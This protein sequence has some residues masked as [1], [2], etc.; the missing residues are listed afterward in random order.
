MWHISFNV[1]SSYCVS[2]SCRRFWMLLFP[3][4]MSE[5]LSDRRSDTFRFC[6]HFSL[7]SENKNSNILTAIVFNDLFNSRLLKSDWPDVHLFDSWCKGRWLTCTPG[8]APVGSICTVLHVLVTE[9][10]SARRWEVCNHVC[11]C[12]TQS[13]T[14]AKKFPKFISCIMAPFKH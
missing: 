12:S 11:F 6:L 8:W 7:S 5:R 9:D 2:A 14:L 13:V 3:I 10:T 1:T 4:C